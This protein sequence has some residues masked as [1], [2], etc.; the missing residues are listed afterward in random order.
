MKK[1]IILL[2][3]IIHYPLSIINS[4]YAL[5]SVSF[6]VYPP[7]ISIITPPN[8]TIKVP[9][10]I[11]NGGELETFAFSVS[12]ISIDLYGT[13]NLSTQSDEASAWLTI[14]NKDLSKSQIKLNANEEASLNLEIKV[15]KNTLENDHYISLVV[16]SKN[17][18]TSDST[19]VRSIAQIA[20]PIILS[21]KE[22]SE[23]ESLIVE[24]FSLPKIS[25]SSEIPVVLKLKN[26][27]K[28]LIETV[29]TITAKNAGGAKSQEILPKVPILAGS[30]RLIGQ[31]S[32]K[33]KTQSFGPTT[34][35]VSLLLDQSKPTTV[36]KNVFIIP[37]PALIAIVSIAT[38]LAL[39]ISKKVFSRT[40][41]NA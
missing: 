27:G 1:L 31:G 22:S 10:K 37:F 19:F 26:P 7:K 21:I 23:P 29:G 6:G 5:S 39:F 28:F 41:K 4:A 36:S 24:E 17:E 40:P 16:S 9:L 15:P 38:G 11:I 14:D 12:P 25:F 13:I 35:T 8:Q 18:E 32:Y 33:F 20:I 3:I 2:I 30:S 34:I